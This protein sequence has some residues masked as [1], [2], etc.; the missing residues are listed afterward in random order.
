MNIFDFIDYKE[1]IKLHIEENKQNYG[2]KSKLAQAAGCQKS[3]LSQ[4]LNSHVHLTPEHAFG[5]SNFWNLDPTK[6][7]YFLTLV[8]FQRSGNKDLKQYLKGKLIHLQKNNKSLNSFPYINPELINLYASSWYFSAIYETLQTMKSLSE[9]QI[10]IRLKLPM[11]LVRESL[12]VLKRMGIVNNKYLS[13]EHLTKTIPMN[14]FQK[15]LFHQSWSQKACQ[16][17]FINGSGIHT[18]WIF[19]LDSQKKS[20]LLKQLE[21]L[22]KDIS[23][24]NSND[25]YC[26][27][28]D[29]FQI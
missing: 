28:I 3:F 25:L 16:K 6:Q 29:F 15:S 17:S 20:L 11:D 5:L 7:E 21:L 18:S 2:Y 8:N 26:L 23:E 13:W 4:V 12:S 22:T 9:E 14:S 27:N 10:S 19:S 24:K 1:Y